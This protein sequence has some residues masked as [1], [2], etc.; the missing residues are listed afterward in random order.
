MI[1]TITEIQPLTS[2]LL[3]VFNATSAC[4]LELLAISLAESAWDLAD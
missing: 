1:E 3:D 2:A 4:V